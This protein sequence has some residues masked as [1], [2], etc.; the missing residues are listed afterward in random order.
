QALWKPQGCRWLEGEVDA[1]EGEDAP[2]LASVSSRGRGVGPIDV[3]TGN[4]LRQHDAR[5][6]VRAVQFRH[7][8]RIEER[9]RRVV[10]RGARA[11]LRTPHL[12]GRDLVDAETPTLREGNRGSGSE[13]EDRGCKTSNTAL[14]SLPRAHSAKL[15]KKPNDS[16]GYSSCGCYVRHANH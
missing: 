16:Q 5:Q 11:S 4:H 7:P 15:T 13:P 12:W 14:A 2:E 6:I 9:R 10:G 8:G 1:A 3:E